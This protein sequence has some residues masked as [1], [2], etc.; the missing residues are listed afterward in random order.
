MNGQT[1]P[2]SRG[3]CAARARPRP[4]RRPALPPSPAVLVC[5][6]GCST[7]ATTGGVITCSA[8]SAGFTLSGTSCGARARRRSAGTAPCRRVG[9]GLGEAG[10]R[11]A[12]RR[13][14]A[15]PAPDPTAPRGP[16]ACSGDADPSGRA[17]FGR[18]QSLRAQLPSVQIPGARASIHCAVCVVRCLHVSLGALQAPAGMVACISARVP[19]M[20]VQLRAERLPFSHFF[21]P[22]LQAFRGTVTKVGGSG[23]GCQPPKPSLLAEGPGAGERRGG[24]GPERHSCLVA[25]LV[26]AV[27]TCAPQ[28]RP[29][30]RANP[31][32]LM[33]RLP[34]TAPFAPPYHIRPHTPDDLHPVCCWIPAKGARARGGGGA[35]A[36]TG[37]EGAPP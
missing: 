24:C 14:P 21:P 37:V 33:L 6:I 27:P 9:M 10:G 16:A 28:G 34:H 35:L 25:A 18:L 8:C 4:T 26:S 30:W 29:A 20:G 5:P 1:Y 23:A 15:R 13:A 11:R 31:A 19:L 7:C 22:R 2:E 17:N 12:R 32:D 36:R 3:A